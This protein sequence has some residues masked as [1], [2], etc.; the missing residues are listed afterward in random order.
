MTKKILVRILSLAVIV[1]LFFLIK[2]DP[3]PLFWGLGLLVLY[4]VFKRFLGRNKDKSQPN[5]P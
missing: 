1:F 2:N 5:P 4:E 3:Y